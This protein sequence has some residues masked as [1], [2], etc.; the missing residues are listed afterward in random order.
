[1]LV[2][3]LKNHLF[4]NHTLQK[5]EYYNY[6]TVIFNIFDII[7]FL[8]FYYIFYHIIDKSISKK[9]IKYGSW[10]F[11]ATCIINLF[12]QDF[13]LQPQNYAILI[14]AIILL[15]AVLTYLY[16]IL[17]KDQKLPVHTN[18]TF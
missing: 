8:Y 14:G 1:M 12:L 18:L 4:D 7:F 9:I 11:L 6:N 10:V 2:Y 16:Q 15:Y 17:K 13:Y 3:S 5:Q